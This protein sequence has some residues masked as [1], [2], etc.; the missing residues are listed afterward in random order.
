M[1]RLCTIC[2]RGGSKGVPGKNIRNLHGKPL[3]VH[4]IERARQSGLF[5]RIAVSSESQE[6]L[7]V[8]KAAGADDLIERPAD[9]ASDTAAKIPAIHHA[10]ATVEKQTGTRYCTL[11]DLDAT[12]PLRT[13]DDIRGAVAL[14]EK[15]KLSSVITG[16]ASHRSPYFN[17]VEERA[18]GSIGV[19]KTPG[20]NVVRRQDA[21]RTFD[22]NASIYVW[23]ADIFRQNPKVFYD[24]TRLFEMPAERSHDIDSE[25]DFDIVEGLFNRAARPKMGNAFPF[26]LRGKVA[27]ITGATGILGQHFVRALAASGADV[28]A[29]DLDYRLLDE[30]SARIAGETGAR[31]LGI[32]CDITDKAALKIAVDRIEATLGPIDILHNNAATKGPDLKAMF[33]SIENYDSQTWRTIMGVNL[34]AMFFVAQEIGPRMVRRGRGSI[35]QTSSIYG[36]MG[37]DN[38]IYEGS[39]YLGETINTPP[40]YAA[41]KAGVIGL[42]KYLAAMWGASNVRVNT[43][44]PGGVESGQNDT[45]IQRYSARVPMG[46]MAKAEEMVGA[47]IF[48]ASDA[49]SYVT[50]QTLMIDG[51]LSAW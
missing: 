22:M 18:D 29:I 10:L 16:A 36:V 15:A 21:P 38:R 41:S 31:V 44:V 48:L 35:I 43:L 26:T 45:F 32:A 12:S 39:F 19:A 42:T 49:S 33:A 47:L 4:S 37:P 17:L 51:G 5:E 30:Q 7:A 13:E 46:R 2:A 27:V 23:N 20:A 34:D 8:A 9:M 28:A 25:L 40:V 11:V 1:K 3:I 14:L 24:D 6:I 50:G